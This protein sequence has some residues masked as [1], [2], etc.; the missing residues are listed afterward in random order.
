[1][2]LI[3]HFT[4]THCS[5]AG[6]TF[7]VHGFFLKQNFFIVVLSHGNQNGYLYHGNQNGYLHGQVETAY[8]IIFG[9]V[10]PCQ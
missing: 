2:I 1:M 7:W 3:Q 6:D 5:D 9:P 8:I 10:G 4:P